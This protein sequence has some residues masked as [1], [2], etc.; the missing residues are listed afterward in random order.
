MWQ[1]YTGKLVFTSSGWRR[2][3]WARKDGMNPVSRKH[4][5]AL[6]TI[7]PVNVNAVCLVLLGL[8]PFWSYHKIRTFYYLRQMNKI[9]PKST[10]ICLSKGIQC[11]K[12]PKRCMT[13]SL[14]QP[15]KN[16]TN[17]IDQT[18]GKYSPIH[19]TGNP[20]WFS[21]SIRIPNSISL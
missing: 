13:G 10:K 6:F 9:N 19:L 18:M 4:N 3:F 12:D 8:I 7:A 15:E 17:V 1:N 21:S 5:D 20:L 2:I 11:C 14:S 16:R